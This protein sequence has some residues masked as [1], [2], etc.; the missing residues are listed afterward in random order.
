MLGEVLFRVPDSLVAGVA[1]GEISRIGALLL[2]NETGRIVAHM[3]ETGA[4]RSA[5]Q[6][7]LS[8]FVR[9]SGNP[10]GLGMGVWQI[11]QNEQIKF[12][13]EQL[14]LLQLGDL[15]LSGVGFG[16]TLTNIAI[17]NGKVDR[18]AQAV[19]R[20][21]DALDAIKHAVEGLERQRLLDQ[22]ADL[23]TACERVE[24]GWLAA[25]SQ[26]RWRKAAEVLHM[27]QNRF[28]SRARAI[29]AAGG[30][31]T[32]ALD[33]IIETWLLAG[34]TRVTACVAADDLREAE[35][36]AHALALELAATTGHLGV[37]ELH[38]ADLRRAPPGSLRSKL[39]E[40]DS[41][42]EEAEARARGYRLREEAVSGRVLMIRHLQRAG[43]DGREY[44]E[45]FRGSDGD[46]LALFMHR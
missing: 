19:D 21:E 14:K 7:L 31:A 37:L 28:A 22:L 23:R 46:P 20:I 34:S 12:M 2:N 15:L 17:I 38:T 11:V 9:T 10:L 27:L 18:L 30:A 45:R 39:E 29:A 24:E 32:P 1:N 25:D 26:S 33:V 35:H 5:L 13:L 40:F 44:L 4:M 36:A 3:Q 41:G 42:R 43:L 16:A 6:P 8:N